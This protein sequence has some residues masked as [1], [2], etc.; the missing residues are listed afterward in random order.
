MIIFLIFS[1]YF[2]CSITQEDGFSEV[3]RG[4]KKRKASGSP[5]LPSP[6]GHS[7]TKHIGGGG[8][9]GSKV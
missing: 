4:R 8:G 5:T 6:G 1:S 9:A 2:L 7:I 3:N